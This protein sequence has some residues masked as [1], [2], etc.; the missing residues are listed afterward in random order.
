MSGKLPKGINHFRV[1]EAIILGRNV[2]DRSPWQD[3]RQDTVIAVGEIVELQEK[4]SM[5]VGDRGQDAFGGTEEFVD[6]GVRRRA[7]VNL[8]R[9]DVVIN[10][11][12]P[13]DEGIEVLGGSSDHLILDVDA[14]RRPLQVGDEIAFS[15]GYGALLALSTSVYVA[16]QVVNT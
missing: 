8:G 1:G 5:P 9:Q 6:R 2:I 7:I 12:T 11:I 3:T 13:L 4:P 15:P 10:G 14:C 16:K